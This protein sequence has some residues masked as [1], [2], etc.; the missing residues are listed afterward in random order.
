M[1][2]H[3]PAFIKTHIIAKYALITSMLMYTI[4]GFNNSYHYV[5]ACM[6]SKK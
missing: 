1:L 4:Q 3:E 5:Y 6:E 2:K